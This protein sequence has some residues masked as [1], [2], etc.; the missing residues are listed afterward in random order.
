MELFVG[1]CSFSVTELRKKERHTDWT[2]LDWTGRTDTKHSIAVDSVKDNSNTISSGSTRYYIANK[3]EVQYY[4]FGS[5]R[6]TV[7]YQIPI[8]N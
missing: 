3:Y 7:S 5:P 6:K 4:D 1:Q 2:G 8:G